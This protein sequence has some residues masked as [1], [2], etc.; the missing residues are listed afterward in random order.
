MFCCDLLFARYL[1]PSKRIFSVF[2]RYFGTILRVLLGFL[3]F[4]DE[5]GEGFLGGGS[6]AVLGCVG[7]PADDGAGGVSVFEG[8][9][10]GFGELF[11]FH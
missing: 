11:P 5:L 3:R 2:S 7:V 1:S 10:D 8:G 6:V 4:L 9:V